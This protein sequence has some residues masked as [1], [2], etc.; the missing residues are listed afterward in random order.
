MP[1]RSASFG[2]AAR[3]TAADGRCTG[4]AGEAVL[5]PGAASLG[6]PSKLAAGGK[7][8][9]SAINPELNRISYVR[10]TRLLSST[11]R[12]GEGA[13]ARRPHLLGVFRKINRAK[14]KIAGMRNL[15]HGITLGS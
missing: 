8:S 7:P 1:E 4:A 12:M 3:G 11:A 15:C 14:R 9:A 6:R 5:A 13:I 10:I 2:V